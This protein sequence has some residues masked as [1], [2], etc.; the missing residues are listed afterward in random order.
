MWMISRSLLL[1]ML[2]AL[3][4]SGCGSKQDG[5]SSA[6]GPASHAKKTAL[7]AQT[8]Q[9]RNMVGAVATNKGSDIPL[10]VRF[11]VQQRPDVGQP[12]DVDLL[13]IP[14]SDT[15]DQVRGHVQVDDGL[16]LV[17]GADIPATQHPQPGVPITHSIKVLP[18][19]DGIFTFSAV[20][21]V[22]A[23]GQ[24]Q[25]QT[26]SMPIIAGS[27]ITTLPANTPDKSGKPS[28]PAT[29]AATR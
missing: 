25:T 13:I 19:R 5:S 21:S 15:L 11:Q 28:Q 1:V 26:Y 7:P 24:S 20:L 23:S 14:A 2:V 22:D 9:M 18:Q 27:G 3:V 6:S 10:T 29:A 12:V 4:S 8:A 17:S 16:E